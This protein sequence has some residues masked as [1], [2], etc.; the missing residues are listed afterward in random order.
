MVHAPRGPRRMEA[1]YRDMLRTS[2]APAL[3]EQSKYLSIGHPSPAVPHAGSEGY[4]ALRR[5]VANGAFGPAGQYDDQIA[6]ASFKIARWLE[7][8]APWLVRGGLG[9]AQKLWQRAKHTGGET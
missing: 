2:A 9:L 6:F 8:R 5:K 1:E 7:R 4:D 3:R